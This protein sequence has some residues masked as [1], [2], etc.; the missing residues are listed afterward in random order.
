MDKV[1]LSSRAVKSTDNGSTR[2]SSRAQ[3]SRA[4]GDM[5]TPPGNDVPKEGRLGRRRLLRE[6]NKA[7]AP[8][9]AGSPSLLNRRLEQP[10]QNLMKNPNNE[11]SNLRKQM[12][13][14]NMDDGKNL[15]STPTMPSRDISGGLGTVGDVMDCT[16]G[17]NFREKYNKL[18]AEEDKKKGGLADSPEQEVR[19]ISTLSSRNKG[20]GFRAQ[21]KS[22]K[23]LSS[24]STRDSQKKSKWFK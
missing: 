11:K 22:N 24:V 19:H 15:A 8:V 17:L 23:S 18:K 7:R 12:I 21:S 10:G 6:P 3:L 5:A 13:H 16:L 2:R 9:L 14:G 20:G 1:K 4:A